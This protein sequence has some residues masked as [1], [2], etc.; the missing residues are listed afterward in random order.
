MIAS[1]ASEGDRKMQHVAQGETTPRVLVIGYG[2]DLRSD[3]GIGPQV[4]TIVATW[5]LP[6]VRSLPLHQLTPELAQLL[7]T[8]DLAI[9]VDAYPASNGQ[10]VQVCPVEPCRSD[11]VTSHTSDPRV[12]LTLAQV[13]YGHHP[14]AWLI[15]VPAANFE[16]G[17]RLSSVAQRGI[18]QA[19][20]Q[21][22]D[23]LESRQLMPDRAGAKSVKSKHC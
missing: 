16:L 14:Q 23:L 22:N 12:L 2:N 5:N 18:H 10:Q 21:I 19:L 15:A 20:E 1:S 13:L 11:L 4:A 17:H 6:R 7:A 3:D 8:V 9:F